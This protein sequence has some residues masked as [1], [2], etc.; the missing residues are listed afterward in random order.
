MNRMS[1]R[2]IRTAVFTTALGITLAGSGAAQA[3]G[4]GPS[5]TYDSA[6]GVLTIPM[7]SLYTNTE[8]LYYSAVLT[9]ASV[10]PTTFSITSL[11]ELTP[12]PNAYSSNNYDTYSNTLYLYDVDVTMG[13]RSYRYS[14]DLMLE[15]G[16]F[17]LGN[18][19]DNT[20]LRMDSP[21]LTA[22]D[23]Y[24]SA[25]ATIPTRNTCDG[26]DI[27]P[28]LSWNSAPSGTVSYAVYGYD[29]NAGSSG[30]DTWVHWLVADI[31]ADAETGAHTL[32]GG[33]QAGG[34]APD[35]GVN[36][37]NSWDET[38][39]RGPCPPTGSGEHS[40]FFKVYALDTTLNL[41][42]GFD[43]DAFIAAADGHILQEAYVSGVYRRD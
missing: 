2:S 24:S 11:N 37:N 16:E 18:L 19:S 40:Y 23:D 29:V 22:S 9:L 32:A 38:G 42:E 27:S 43:Y 17:V 39:Y 4:Y 25:I 26:S 31:P 12:D 21:V 10:S 41:S 8:T 33:V 20:Y 35:G 14:V 15:G 1:N 34:A 7:V 5:P 3:S 6:T 28:E 36:G 30:Y 13:Q